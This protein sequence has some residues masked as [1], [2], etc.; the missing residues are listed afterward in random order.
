MKSSLPVRPDT[1][2]FYFAP[3]AW[4]KLLW[5]WPCGAER[6]GWFSAFRPHTNPLYVEDF[7]TVK[8]YATSVTFASTTKSVAELFDRLVD[9]GLPS[10]SICPSLDHTHPGDSAQPS[11]VDEEETF[12]RTFGN[13]DWASCF[14]VSRSA[15]TYARL[16]F[17]AG[18][19]GQGAAACCGPLADLPAALTNGASLYGLVAQWGKDYTAHVNKLPELALPAALH[20]TPEWW[21]ARPWNPDLDGTFYEPLYQGVIGELALEHS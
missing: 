5:F 10:T 21:T 15:Q 1:D 9:Q 6:G 20:P 16:S 19:G 8:Q 13:C 11:A 14:I 12:A 18:P 2:A 4:L 3:L 7:V 17:S